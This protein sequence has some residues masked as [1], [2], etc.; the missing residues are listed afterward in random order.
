MSIPDALNLP[1]NV[2]AALYKL[3]IDESNDPKKAE[4]NANQAAGEALED[5]MGGMM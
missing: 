3:A 1:L 5:M 4:A 2:I